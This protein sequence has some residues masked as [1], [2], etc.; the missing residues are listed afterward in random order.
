MLN[1]E[2]RKMFRWEGPR[3]GEGRTGNMGVKKKNGRKTIDCKWRG[4]EGKERRKMEKKE[5]EF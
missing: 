5:K 2:K 4:E 3:E 1:S